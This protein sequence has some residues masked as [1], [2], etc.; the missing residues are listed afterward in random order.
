MPLDYYDGWCVR[1]NKGMLLTYT[2]ARTK[3]L[4]VDAIRELDGK[5]SKP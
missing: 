2:F 4:A 3:A 1:D 5:G